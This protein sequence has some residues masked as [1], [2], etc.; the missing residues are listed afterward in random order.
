MKIKLRNALLIAL[1]LCLCVCLL[2]ACGGDDD[3]PENTDDIGNVQAPA[4]SL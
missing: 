3:T 4:W 1:A 2:S